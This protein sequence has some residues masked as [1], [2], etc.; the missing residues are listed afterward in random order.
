VS[1]AAQV[2]IERIEDG[3]VLVLTL[4]RPKANVLTVAMMTELRAALARARTDSSLKMVMLRGAGKSFSYGA[5]VDEHRKD[6]AA[7]ML[8]T[9]HA[10][11]REVAAFPVPV[12]AVVEGKC[13]GGAFELVLACHVVLAQPSAVFACPEVKLGVIPPVLGVIGHLR[14]GAATAERMLLT[15]CE[16]DG[17]R[18]E[19]LGFVELAPADADMRAF[20]IDWYRANLASL[21]AFTLREA[22]H[23]TR[24][25]SSMVAALGAGLDAAERRYLDRIVASRDGNEGIEAFL[26][27]RRPQWVDA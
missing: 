15:G 2:A 7:T 24:T 4:D 1:E 5:S 16:I 18:A 17:A 10:L 8:G 13:L 3:R 26:A 19:R 9:F 20:A 25:G 12:V 14:L 23:A 6:N 22:T 11:V 27:K 21:S